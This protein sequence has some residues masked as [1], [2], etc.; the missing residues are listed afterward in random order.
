MKTN[1]LSTIVF[2]LG[3][4]SFTYCTSAT[5]GGETATFKVYGNCEMCKERIEASL[6]GVKGVQSAVWNV[7]S[8]IMKVVYDS[9]VV[10]VDDVQKKIAAVGHD[11]EKVSANGA[12]YNELPGC[13]QYSRK[14]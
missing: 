11:T 6:K 9:K 4:L 5:A 7:D 10:S 2:L 14:K 3:I 12:V 13:C 8:K 1:L